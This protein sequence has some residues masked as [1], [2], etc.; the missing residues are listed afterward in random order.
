MAPFPHP[1]HRTGQA[2]F[3]HP[4]LGQDVTLS[5][6]TPSAASEHLLEL[7]GFPISRSFTTYCVCLE[8]R[9]LPSTGV[10][11]LPRYYEPLRHPRAPSLSLTGFRL[12]IADHALGLPVF[13]ALS[14]CTCRRHY[15]G[16]ASERIAS[17]ISSRRISLPRKGCRVDLRIVLFEDC[18]AF[19][20]VAACTLAL[21]PIRDTLIEGFSHFVASMTA[22]IASGWSGCRVGLAPTGKRRLCT[23]HTL[24]WTFVS[25]YMSITA[26]FFAAILCSN[27]EQRLN[28][29][30]RGYALAAL[31]ACLA[32]IVGYFQ[33]VPRLSDLFVLF[34]RARGTFNDPN[35]LG[36]FV[37]FP[38]LIALQ[39]VL[40][41]RL[42]DVV[43]G[44]TVL[45]V[46]V[47]GLFLSFSRAA[48]G[49]FVFAAAIMLFL[50]FITGNS[51]KE[52]ARI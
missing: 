40:A 17:L 34:G 4:A 15:P 2:D 52:R 10:T 1:A 30:V 44:G 16:A 9:S 51:S 7:I 47:I 42:Q 46:L 29:L 50:M 25:W 39:R 27:T 22:P 49:Q 43:R 3:P 45:T 32:G 14:L 37:V 36:A 48:W 6:A 18:S 28:L 13:R 5:R 26:M 12:V 33:L 31:V 20:R 41:G 11:R 23:A 8:L 24:L 38:A 21:S 35:V 19:T